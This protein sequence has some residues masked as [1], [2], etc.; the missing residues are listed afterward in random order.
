MK[1]LNPLTIGDVALPAGD[2]LKVM[3]VNQEDLDAALP[4]SGRK[5]K[6]FG[7][8]EQTGYYGRSA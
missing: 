4:E 7:A 8:I 2:V 1:V 5:D 6:I 3:G